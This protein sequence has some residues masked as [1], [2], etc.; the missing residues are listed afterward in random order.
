MLLYIKKYT[1]K[2]PMNNFLIITL[3][4]TSMLVAGDNKEILQEEKEHLLE[5]CD[6]FEALSLARMMQEKNDSGQQTASSEKR[7]LISMLHDALTASNEATLQP[8]HAHKK[9]IEEDIDISE[10]IKGS[11]TGSSMEDVD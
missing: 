6:F 3:C 5:T 2:V 9:L 8:N 1:Y 4:C 10:D 11:N 7:L